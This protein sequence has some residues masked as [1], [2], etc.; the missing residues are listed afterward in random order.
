MLYA[1]LCDDKPNSLQ[2]RMDTRAEHLAHL[3]GLGDALKFACPFLD[4]NDKPCG[5]MVVIEAESREA[6]KAIADRDPYAVAGL[7]ET[8]TVRP[9]SWA[10]KNPAAG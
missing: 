10:I 9:W 7:F 5:S 3:N 4:E 2:L 8:V 6:A 1:L